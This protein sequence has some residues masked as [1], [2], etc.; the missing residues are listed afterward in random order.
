M[1]TEPIVPA[2]VSFDQGTPYS[3]AFGDVYHP[4]AGALAQAQHVFLGGN[5]LPGRWQGRERFVVLETGFGLGNNFLATWQAWRADPARC[6]RLVFV[7][8]EKHPLRREDLQRVHAG[9]PLPALAAQLVAAWPPLTPN[10]H[11][12]DFE[13][14]R[15]RL[16]LALGDVAAWLPEITAAVDAFYL[17]G[18][19]PPRNPAM[20]DR[21]VLKAV[22]RLAAP[23]ATAATWSVARELR[24][25]LVEAGFVVHKAEGIGG[26]WQM[27]VARFAPAFT[28]RRALNRGASAV[29]GG[30]RVLVVG[31]GLAG[32]AAARAL[33]ARGWDV[34]VAERHA[35]PAMETSG[36]AAGLLHGVVTPEDGAHA[37]FNRAAALRAQWVYGDG[38]SGG[39]P[40]PSN[41]TAHPPGTARRPDEIAPEGPLQ[42]LLRLHA[43]Q[44]LADMQAWLQR[45]ALPADYVRAVDAAEASALAGVRLDAPAWHYPGG[46]WRVP[47]GVVRAGLHGVQ[48][49]LWQTPVAALREAPGGWQAL[50]A[51]GRLIAEADAVLLANAHDA[52][53]LLG[54]PG[55]PITAVRG[56]VTQLRS[57]W[58]PR[59]PLAGAGYAIALPAG[60]LLCGATQQPLDTDPTLREA[61]HLANLANLQR[62]SGVLHPLSQ[63]TGGRVGWRMV[64]S[65]RLP[66]LGALPDLSSDSARRD[67]PRLLPRRPGLFTLTALGSRGLTWAPLAGEILAAW[68]SGDPLPIESSLLD[69]VDVARFASRAAR[70]GER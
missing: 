56:Q 46:G 14:G 25:G 59:L 16:L 26:K 62:L 61:D 27:S 66:V 47:A 33:A 50:D 24:A 22:G 5:Q 19:A 53:R 7:S 45:Q 34:T 10:L 64:S 54:Q 60:E 21:Q 17:D 39:V 20:W 68:M 8:V 31:A 55:W 36:N 67:Q 18:F 58:R 12:L 42:G 52:L 30:R 28:P 1:K 13:S 69:S 11:T 41:A 23:G 32:A 9:S 6:E 38:S 2:V 70:R 15:V 49:C 4:R 44:P 37:R 3:A 35:R 29:A 63:V 40:G 51:D 48:R 65:D 57:A 43:E